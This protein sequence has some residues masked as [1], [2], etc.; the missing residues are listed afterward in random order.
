MTE[1]C[2]VDYGMGNLFSVAHAFEFLGA[3]VKISSSPTD[4]ADCNAIV[5]PGVG[6]FGE[7]MERLNQS[8]LPRALRTEVLENEKPIFGICLG[9]QLFAEESTENGLHK[10]LALIRGRIDRIPGEP[11]IR[12]PHVGWNN[13]AW[14]REE[15]LFAN[16]ALGASFYFDHSYCFFA[17]ED[18]VV[19]TTRCAGDVNAALRRHNIFA[20]QFH[21][22]KSQNNGLRV[23]RNFLRYVEAG[24]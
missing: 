15:L 4:L 7:A 13:V 5:L 11:Q 24:R 2:I 23:L 3:Q 14:S 22:E 21:P 8:G 16:I 10:G 6:A 20:T 1:I 9:M 12:L 19:G 17:D 18:V